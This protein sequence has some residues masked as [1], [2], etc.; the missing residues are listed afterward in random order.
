MR[1]T[2][3]DLLPDVGE[4]HVGRDD[5]E[6]AL[7]HR[8]DRAVPAQV[9][10]PPA[11]LGKSGHPRRS[12][13]HH[14]MRV[15]RERRQDAAVGHREGDAGEAD[16]RLAL[17]LRRPAGPKPPAQRDQCRLDLA[18]QHRVNAE[19]A[20]PGLVHRRVEPVDAEVCLWREPSEVGERRHGDA[21]CR[22]HAHVDGDHARTPEDRRIELLQRQVE[23]GH[24]KAVATQ[25]RRR[26]GEGER[27][28]AQ[29]VGV[30][31]NDL[32]GRFDYFDF[33]RCG[34]GAGPGSRL[35]P[36]ASR[37]PR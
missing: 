36:A 8:D 27:L 24:G 32:D 9:L 22:V 17:A 28:P 29:L 2:G 19:F 20:Q 37:R 4:H 30:D 12:V 18:A 3:L 16:D 13:R 25:Q 5:A 10:A 33:G 34:N 15:A 14:E 7:V 11:A 6:L 31:E 26:G 21:G 23:A 1:G 35:A